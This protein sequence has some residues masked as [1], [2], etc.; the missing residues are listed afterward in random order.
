MRSGPGELTRAAE[1]LAGRADRD[2]RDDGAPTAPGADVCPSRAARGRCRRPRDPRPSRPDRAA[3]GGGR[4]VRVDVR[5][6]TRTP[7]RLR[8]SR[9][10]T[11]R[12]VRA[13]L[14]AQPTEPEPRSEPPAAPA[15]SPSPDRDRRSRMICRVAT[16]R[17]ETDDTRRRAPVPE[18]SAPRAPNPG[19]I[20][21]GPHPSLH[22]ARLTVTDV[23]RLWPEVLEEVKGKRRFTWILLS[24]N[25]HVT[26]RGTTPCSWPCPR[27]GARDS[28]G[29]GGQRGRAAGGDRRR[30]RRGPP[31]RDHRRSERLARAAPRTPARRRARD[32]RRRR[33]A[34]SARR[35]DPARR[36]A[37]P[38]AA[39][40]RP[41]PTTPEGRSRADDRTP[42]PVATATMPTSTTRRS[43]PPTCWPATSTRRSSPRTRPAHIGW[44]GP[45]TPD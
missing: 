36:E 7:R 5:P 16:G 11:S 40:D 43:R 21:S 4:D 12:A 32:P 30:P 33:R 42:T 9:V 44:A 15:A 29:R 31:D 8:S 39:S 38:A 26:E 41:G 45:R 35:V 18:Q 6:S 25:A 27:S 34:D 10:R 23:R 2:A 20:E 37:G 13:Q 3:P 14:P 24:Q 22:E 17:A 28:F 19:R 1:V